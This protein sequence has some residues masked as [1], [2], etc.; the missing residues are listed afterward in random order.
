M[1]NTWISATA[2]SF[3]LASLIVV[4]LC[5]CGGKTTI[6]PAS[7]PKE[8]EVGEL[9]PTNEAPLPESMATLQQN[10][11]VYAWVDRLNIRDA[12]NLNGKQVA[13]VTEQEAL[14]FTGEKSD[15]TETIVLRGVAYDEPWLK[16]KTKDGKEG[17]VFGG[18]VKREGETKGNDPISNE[19]FFFPHFGRFDLSTW[20][21][22]SPS[23]ES[24]GDVETTTTIYKKNGRTLEISQTEVGEYSYSYNYKLTESDST[25]L[26]TRDFTFVADPELVISEVVNVYTSNPPVQYYRSQQVQKHFMQLNERPVMANGAWLEGG[27]DPLPKPVNIGTVAAN[28]PNVDFN[29]GCSCDFKSA[30]NYVFR[31]DFKNGCLNVDGQTVAVK[32]VAF[33]DE[34]TKLIKQS[35]QQPWIVLNEKGDNLIFGKKLEMGSQYEAHRAELVRT[36][37]VMDDLPNEINYQSNG[38]VGMGYR[39]EVR[40]LCS[41]AIQLAKEA[42]KR[43]ETGPPAELRFQNNNYKVQFTVKSTG[44]DDGGGNY[45]EGTMEIQTKDGTVLGSRQ[46]KGHCGC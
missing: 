7:A 8:E 31:S 3:I 38:T 29:D 24:E 1:K 14:E 44:R 2:D 5:A 4:L 22:Q 40:D 46:V 20:E 19:R 17:W 45:Y 37:L 9:D 27:S 12:A 18:A 35:Q 42:K 15:N 25:V 11:K 23:N 26:K 16:V 28:C 21:K 13:S 34:R 33:E 32:E 6:E 36:L 41:E 43:G 39:A 30:D 10:E